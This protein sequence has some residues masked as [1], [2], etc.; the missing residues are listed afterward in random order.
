MTVTEYSESFKAS[1]VKKLMMPRGPTASAL[2][3]RTGI[4]Q[5]TLSR[6]LRDAKEE[7]MPQSKLPVRGARRPEEWG[8]EEKLALLTQS[9]GLAGEDLGE[10]LRREGVHE[11]DLAEWRS[12][13]LVGLGT[14]PKT[15]AVSGD[16][17]RVREL[18]RELLRK[19]KA[20]AETAALLVLKKKVQ[21]YWGDEDDSTKKET[22]K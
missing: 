21:E 2:S 5:P 19:D 14:R 13:A 8:P 9:E 11:A 18:E 12:A 3:I 4:C 6:W 16:A 22:D 15:S 10:L 7:G 1:M 17:R 20:L